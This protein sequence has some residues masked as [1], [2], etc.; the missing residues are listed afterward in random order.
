MP[1]EL[2]RDPK[3]EVEGAKEG[4]KSARKDGEE[5]ARN[6][7][8][9]DFTNFQSSRKVTTFRSVGPLPRCE[10]QHPEP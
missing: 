9:A 5:A 1:E 3:K 2:L 8:R 6:W 7:L 4:K 10:T